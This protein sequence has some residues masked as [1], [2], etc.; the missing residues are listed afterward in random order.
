VFWRKLQKIIFWIFLILV[1]F[2]I[3]S[4]YVFGEDLDLQTLRYYIKDLGIWAPTVFV[5]TYI[6]LSIFIPTTP[7]MIIAGLLF[8]FWY[9]L[10]YTF[11]GGLISAIIVFSFCR[12]LGREEVE[13]I[14]KNKYLKKLDEYNKKLAE[15]GVWDLTVLRI[16]PVMPFNVLNILMGISSIKTKDYIL[17]TITGS[18]PSHIVALYLATLASKI[19]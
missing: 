19:I 10:L 14:L 2:S 5:L 16:L 18:M 7:L 4:Y 17:G 8:G 13:N 15:N 12:K 3:V 9:G 1:V 11:V 6:L